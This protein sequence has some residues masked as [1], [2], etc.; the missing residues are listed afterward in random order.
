MRFPLVCRLAVVGLLFCGCGAPV[1]TEPTPAP[2][3]T[4]EA[5]ASTGPTEPDSPYTLEL[6]F[7]PL[8][9]A[10]FEPFQAEPTTW[11]ESDGTLTSTGKPKGYLYSKAEY[12]NFTWRLE[13]RYP[14][15]AQFDEAKFP[16]NTGFL[17]FITG[18]HKIWPICLEVQ[19]KPVQMG[20]VKENGG[21]QA[22]ELEDDDAVRQ[23]V[24]KP[25]GEWQ[26]LEIVAK[27]GALT[28]TLN[29][30]VV[31]RSQP[32]FLSSGPIGI[33]AEN[34]PFIIRRMRI[35]KDE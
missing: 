24:R 32:A 21:A 14:R 28:V 2:T 6:D 3:N 27:D 31:C 1:S 29:D 23:R 16:G 18:E 12:Q 7:T 26:R 9:L 13:Y 25:V 17:V 15:P 35:R 19:G 4:V 30:E 20:I 8:T 22:P 5:P 11:S 33:Q 34:Q 10:D